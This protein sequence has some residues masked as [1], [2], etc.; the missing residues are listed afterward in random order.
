MGLGLM[1]VGAAFVSAKR[2][3]I[4]SVKNSLA[5]AASLLAIHFSMLMMCRARWSLISR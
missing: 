5:A 3:D 4:L 2:S 1:T